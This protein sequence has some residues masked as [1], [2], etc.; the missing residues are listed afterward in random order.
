MKLQHILAAFALLLATSVSAQIGRGGVYDF[1]LTAGDT[2]TNADTLLYT[3]SRE[4]QDDYD[5]T[6]QLQAEN[7]SGTTA[8][9]ATLEERL[10]SGGQWVTRDTVTFDAS[11]AAF[12][13]GVNLG[14]EQ[15]WNIITSNTGVTVVKARVWYRR[16][17]N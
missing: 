2:L 8:V 1:S 16:R 3:V 15:R 10:I 13:T 6:W 12:S 11:G 4:L 17:N 5:F 14:L 9:T 7:I